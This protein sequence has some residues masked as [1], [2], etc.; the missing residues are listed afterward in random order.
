VAVTKP[1]EAPAEAATAAA[2]S[3]GVS[4]VEVGDEISADVF[5]GEL[6]TIAA[7]ATAAADIV[8][9]DAAA[10]EAA[11][12]GVSSSYS[13]SLNHISSS[14]ST[15][16]GSRLKRPCLNIEPTLKKDHKRLLKVDIILNFTLTLATERLNALVTERLGARAPG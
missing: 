3:K 9:E 1:T 2:A 5:K 14:S 4:E 8:G 12:V 16:R 7:A 11:E 6:D 13:S 10:I 15:W